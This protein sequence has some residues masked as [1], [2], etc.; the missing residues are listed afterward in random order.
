M[1]ELLKRKSSA[2]HALRVLLLLLSLILT[3]LPAARALNPDRPPDHYIVKSWGVGEGLP[4]NSVTAIAQTGDG[5]IWLGTYSGLVRFD[6]VTFTVFDKWNSPGI[7]NDRITALHESAD[8]TLW[9][10]TYGG[11]LTSLTGGS[12]KRD[13]TKPSRWRTYTSREGLSNDYITCIASDGEGALWVGTENGLNRIAGEEVKS[14]TA[15]HGLGGSFI[16]SLAK[17]PG[18]GFLIGALDG[19]ISVLE[20]LESGNFKK[21]EASPA[22]AVNAI[23]AGA[24]GRI[25]VGALNGL[26]AMEDGDNRRYTRDDGLSGNAVSALAAS[27]S[28][29]IYIGPAAGGLQL[30]R[31]GSVINLTRPGLF[32][33]VPVRAIFEDRDGNVWVGTDTGGLLQIK[34]PRVEMITSRDGIPDEEIRAVLG[35]RSGDLWVGTERGGLCL[36]EADERR[37]LKAVADL[38]HSDIRCLLEDPDST[39]WVGTEGS[40]L[41]RIAGGAATAF[42]TRD[43]LSSDDV[44]A[45]YRDGSGTLYIGTSRGLNRLRGGSIMAYDRPSGL[46]NAQVRTLY[47]DGRGALHVGTRKGLVKF[48]DHAPLPIYLNEE[49]IEPDVLSIYEDR[50]GILWIGTGGNG[51]IR[52]ENNDVTIYTTR[53]GLPDNH[54][55][56]II[57]DK[58][59]NFYMSSYVGVFRIPLSQLEAVRS[60]RARRFTPALFDETEGLKNRQ[61][62]F[63]GEPSACV[64]PGGRIC[65][66][67]VE[68]VAVLDPADIEEQG[69]PPRAVIEGMFADN[70]AFDMSDANLEEGPHV[71]QFAFTALDFQAPDKL[72]FEYMLEGY[73]EDWNRLARGNPRTAYYFNLDPGNYVFRVRAA[74]NYGAREETG[75]SIEFNI[76]RPFYRRP[77]VYAIIIAALGALAAGYLGRRRSRQT[78]PEK[79]STSALADDRI[80][81]VLPKLEGLM[82]D[83][84]IYLDA[85]LN[86]Q[87]LAARVGIHYNYLSRIINEKFGLSYN[88]YVNG[89]RIEEAKRMLAD[90]ENAEKNILD[91]AYETGF[92]SKSVFNTAF[93]KMTGRTPSRYRKESLEGK[94]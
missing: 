85:D 51:L 29:D 63:E 43:G 41:L 52:Y 82:R 8:G 70:I 62:T 86:L 28:G 6:G 72:R 90:P 71:I 31:D 77:H 11:G 21:H 4:Q 55:F 68:G 19:G 1:T 79:Y 20:D 36:V 13:L 3:C 26:Y 76:E 67:T 23:A 80:Q 81:E 39:L 92:Y 18:G 89:Y 53:E 56:S 91:I 75:A 37:V 59:G 2:A 27:A 45:L 42:S 84:K 83:D 78:K 15:W 87:A 66:P 46:G 61:C 93:K 48:Y 5:Y 94:I 7:V 14:Y 38:P 44:T 12:L 25:W 32:P 30:F 17:N 47:E 35:S 24:N 50:S 74:D 33:D 58:K 9:V 64:D 34:E 10:G 49:G 40:G 54:I 88:D 65:Y 57:E 16:T 22:R 73:D 69:P 60:G